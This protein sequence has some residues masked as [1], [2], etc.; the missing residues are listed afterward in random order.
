MFSR[1]HPFVVHPLA[2]RRFPRVVGLALVLLVSSA[3]AAGFD[4]YNLGT[5]EL[6]ISGQG[7]VHQECA[8]RG[9]VTYSN[10]TKIYGCTDF[11]NRVIVSV[12]DP[13]IIA[14]E[15]CHWATQSDSHD[16]CPTPVVGLQYH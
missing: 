2:R 4:R 7:Q 10:D 3:C 9:A 5:A 12:S 8:R 6:W 11:R 14:H 13:K 15:W 1:T 16:V